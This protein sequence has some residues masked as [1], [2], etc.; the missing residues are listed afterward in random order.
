MMDTINNEALRMANAIDEAAK[1]AAKDGAPPH[2]SLPHNEGCITS[3][4]IALE[5]AARMIRTFNSK[6]F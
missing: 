4:V 2:I 5:E 6:D 1:Q 3:Y